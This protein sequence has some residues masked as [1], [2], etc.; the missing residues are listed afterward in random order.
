VALT[1]REQLAEER[2]RATR[3]YDA[4]VEQQARADRLDAGI[5][6]LRAALTKVRADFIYT[7]EEGEGYRKV[8]E[9]DIPKEIDAALAESQA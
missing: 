6:R 2:A 9:W 7:M 1:E 3:Y 8:A 4:F 5:A